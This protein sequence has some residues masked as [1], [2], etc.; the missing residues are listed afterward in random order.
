MRLASDMARGQLRRSHVTVRLAERV[1]LDDG[2]DD[3]LRHRERY[4]FDSSRSFR[5]FSAINAAPLR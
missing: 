1:G 2:G 3:G 5:F 4:R